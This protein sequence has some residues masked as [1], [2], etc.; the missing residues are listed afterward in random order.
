[1][2][3][4]ANGPAIPDRLVDESLHGRVVFLCGAG[5]SKSA[6]LPL[7]K[8]LVD[9][10]FTRLAEKKDDGEEA[11]YRLGRFEEVLGSLAR[12]LADPRKLQDAVAEELAA[13]DVHD[14]TAHINLLRLSRDFEG[15]SIVVTTNF[16]TLFERAARSLGE[17]RSM[18]ALS[19]AGAQV[20]A[21]GGPRFQGIVHLHG[22]LADPMLGLPRTDLVL[23]SAEFGDAYLRSGWAARFLFDLCRCATVVLVGYRADDPPVR[24]I[25]NILEADRARFPDLRPVY[26]F[27]SFDEQGADAE[28]AKWELIA[29]SAIPHHVQGDDFSPLWEDLARWA[30][31]AERPREWRTNRL[32]ELA[33]RQFASLETWEL[34]QAAWAL[35]HADG[36]RAASSLGLSEPWIRFIGERDLLAPGADLQWTVGK[37][38]AARLSSV[39]A[40]EAVLEQARKL[41]SETGDE[42]LRGLAAGETAIADFLAVG[43]RLLVDSLKQ[44]RKDDFWRQQHAMRKLRDGTAIAP[45]L[46]ALTDLLVPRPSL[47]PVRTDG[48]TAVPAHLSDICQIELEPIR[49]Y[50]LNE[51]LG[52]LPAR[53]NI[54]WPLL[55]RASEELSRTLDWAVDAQRIRDDFD[56]TDS[57]VPSISDHPQNEHHAGFLPLTRLCAEL[58]LRAAALDG[59]RARSFAEPWRTRNRRL[60]TRLWLFTWMH[61]PDRTSDQLVSVLLELDRKDFWTIRKEVIELLMLAGAASSQRKNQL[62]RLILEGDPNVEESDP[63][64]RERVQNRKIWTRLVALGEVGSLPQFAER[65]LASIARRMEWPQRTLEESELFSVYSMDMWWGPIGDPEPIAEAPTEKRVEIAAHLESNDPIN[66]SDAWRVYC[67]SD[68]EGAY[69]ALQCI[70]AS[71]EIVERWSDVLWAICSRGRDGNEPGSQSLLVRVFDALSA[72]PDELLGVIIHSLADAYVHAQKVGAFVDGAWWDR[73]WA[74]SEAAIPER[75]SD[76]G[77][78]DP[79]YALISRAINAPG[80]KLTRLLI[81]PMGPKW[82]ELPPGERQA[83]E[84]RVQRAFSS[85]TTT[86]LHGRA[87]LVEWVAWVHHS[88]P[89]IIIQDIKPALEAD[90]DEGHA[91]RSIFVGISRSVGPQLR[92]LLRDAMFLGVVEHRGSS[93]ALTENAASRIVAEVLA[94][95]DRARGDPERLSAGQAKQI[96]VQASDAIRSAAAEVLADRLT[97]EPA[98]ERAKAWR[99]RFL[100]AWEALWPLDKKYRS[101]NASVALAK[102]AASAENAFPEALSIIAPYLVP[103][104]DAWP[105]FHFLRQTERRDILGRF[106]QEV[107]TL[108]WALLRPPAE[109]RCTDL[110]GILDD[111]IAADTSLAL[112]RRVQLL[113]ERTVR[114]G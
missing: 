13:E 72:F 103:V 7:F 73:I 60:T 46:V 54:I 8:E 17:R 29:V 109:G 61:G 88:L 56:V 86:G 51:I 81:N 100:A 101:E 36:A 20:P 45:D 67:G 110:A 31:L 84:A 47:K 10:I 34:D 37:W 113:E 52:A 32:G 98:G 68:P 1:M 5:I 55:R 30:D 18:E 106:P 74:V 107:V 105:N 53:G 27:A 21:P 99:E 90:T 39:T 48:V 58:W 15:K 83:I 22:R 6:G 80:G 19:F 16:D 89:H 87:V 97:A 38:A 26:A 92:V 24:Y 95:L 112:D 66:Q 111:L 49:D 114:M 65:R 82:E 28:L 3:F 102:F 75:A 64:L 108:L 14:L 59:G 11:A 85:T 104:T 41:T 93:G 9:R 25:L 23:T 43:W 70:A 50:E 91:L 79:G 77:D 4:S 35:R 96:L 62:A 44:N 76:T 12:R 94:D 78:R 63:D 42:I 71:R 2:K 33:A 40:F 69:E 57:D